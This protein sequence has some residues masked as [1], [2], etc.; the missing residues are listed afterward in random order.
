MLKRLWADEGGAILSAEL[1]LIMTMLVIGLIVGLHAVQKAIVTELV[2]IAQAIGKLDQSYYFCGFQQG[3]QG[4]NIIPGAG[5][6]P[7]AL[8]TADG[9]GYAYTAGSAFVDAPD[10]CD[11]LTH[12]TTLPGNEVG[13]V[14]T[15]GG[16]SGPP[17]I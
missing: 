12:V 5:S 13:I 2:D 3:Q 6:A 9:S 4:G 11:T 8:T 14:E 16:G 7:W 15:G 17:G 1:I 10:F